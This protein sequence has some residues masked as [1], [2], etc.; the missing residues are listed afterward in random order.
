M[1]QQVYLERITNPS[2]PDYPAYPW[3]LL[4]ILVVTVAGFL[5]WR[6]WRILSADALRHAGL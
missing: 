1:R 2:Q 6:M 3:R 4:W 5:T